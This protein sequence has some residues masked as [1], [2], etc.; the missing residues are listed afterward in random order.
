[1]KSRYKSRFR[2][3]DGSKVPAPSEHKIQVALMDYLKLALRPELEARAIPNGGR[4]HISVANKL[5]AEGV[6]AGSPDIF[7]C[8]PGGKVAWLEMKAKNGSLEPEQKEFRD[9]VI[10]LGHSYGVA[11][12]VEQ[13]IEYLTSIDALKPAYQRGDA[14]KKAAEIYTSMM[15]VE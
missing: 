2:V 12:S 4:R 6:R 15:G 14:F 8:L 1:M 5:K 13:A 9:K 11:K 10:A 3:I 7:I